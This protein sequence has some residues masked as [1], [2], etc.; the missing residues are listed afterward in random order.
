MHV[1]LFRKRLGRY[2]K[3][4]G[5]FNPY[6]GFQKEQVRSLTKDKHDCKH[7]KE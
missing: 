5:T 6:E 1:L 7:F 4:A 2:K 3:N